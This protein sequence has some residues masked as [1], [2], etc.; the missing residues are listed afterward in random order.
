SPEPPDASPEQVPEPAR[1]GRKQ[2]TEKDFQHSFRARS[3]VQPD[4]GA[5]REARAD[6][7]AVLAVK[8][9]IERTELGRLHLG[10]AQEHEIAR[11]VRAEREGVAEIDVESGR[12][13]Q[14]ETSHVE[15]RDVTPHVERTEARIA[16]AEREVRL[17]RTTRNVPA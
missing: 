8:R 16:A 2:G 3:E 5:Q 4:H 10:P 17:G 1:E 12:G 11:E 13:A 7:R 9:G 6:A 14:I 15:S